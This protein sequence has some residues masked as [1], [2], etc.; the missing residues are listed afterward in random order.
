[1]Q[2]N[3]CYQYD[4][5]NPCQPQQYVVYCQPQPQYCYNP[6]PPQPYCPPAPCPPQPCPCPPIPPV[7][8]A[9]ELILPGVTFT[10]PPTTVTPITT[11]GAPIINRGGFIVDPVTGR[12]TVPVAGRYLVNLVITFAAPTVTQV[13]TTRNVFFNLYSPSLGTTSVILNESKSVSDP[14]SPDTHNVTGVFNLNAGDVLFFTVSQN[15]T[16]PTT[17]FIG[18]ND[19]LTITRLG[20]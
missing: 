1:M 20:A 13:N 9:P 18:A 12:I 16:T 10:V 7:I 5:C 14:T 11:F 2:Y 6:C 3:N 8:P 19:R 17:A 4:P 15:S